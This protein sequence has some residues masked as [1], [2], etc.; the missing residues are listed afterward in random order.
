[1]GALVLA[2]LLGV[3]TTAHAAPWSFE[4]PAGYTEVPNAGAPQVEQLR[5][6]PKAVSGRKSTCR[7]WPVT[8]NSWVWPAESRCSPPLVRTTEEGDMSFMDKITS[9]PRDARAEP[10]A[11]E[12]QYDDV[13]TA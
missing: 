7:H 13:L 11:Y 5:A 9:R 8:S 6:M 12:S 10:G 4:L 3:A 1:M 2:A